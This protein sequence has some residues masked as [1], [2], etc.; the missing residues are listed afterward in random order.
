MDNS[1]WSNQHHHQHDG[2]VFKNEMFI[3]SGDE[4]QQTTPSS[5]SIT[6][7][8]E[9]A[10]DNGMNTNEPLI[11]GKPIMSWPFR[12]VGTAML[13]AVI[14]AAGVVFKNSPTLISA[15]QITTTTAATATETT[16][17]L[18]SS[19]EPKNQSDEWNCTQLDPEGTLWLR[20]NSS[21]HLTACGDGWNTKLV[22]LVCGELGYFGTNLNFTFI[23]DSKRAAGYDMFRL[24]EKDQ[25]AFELIDST[26]CNKGILQLHCQ[27]Y[28]CGRKSNQSKMDERYQYKNIL[29]NTIC[30]SLALAFSNNAAIKCTANIVS[31]RW[32]LTSYTC[33]EGKKEFVNNR[34]VGEMKWKLHAGSAEFSAPSEMP[35]AAHID[36][37]LQI[38]DVKRV[39]PYRQNYQFTYTGDVVLLELAT[40]LHLNDVIGSVCLTETSST[41]DP[42][43]RC[44]TTGW[45]S[46]LE[47]TDKMEQYMTNVS[48]VNVHTERC[49]NN[50]RGEPLNTDQIKCINDTGAPLMCYVAA[51][52]QWQLQGVLSIHGNCDKS[53]V[54]YNPITPD[55]ANWI[56][57]TV[58]NS[59][60]F[61]QMIVTS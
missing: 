37:S 36:E 29:Q 39:V 7:I 55:I 13:V 43:Q 2:S 11:N 61:E 56:R 35:A 17:E 38:V 52:G 25:L 50:I 32:A 18:I 23:S 24:T 15:P 26:Q 9:H 14:L 59:R 47:H 8:N 20:R 58:G 22:G 41:I 60:M 5:H 51:T 12:L 44:L 19:S 21:A 40:P 48:A 34:N 30:P 42:K 6:H 53:P 16:N 10:V 1:N 28:H 4:E 31:P 57:N 3:L 33:I 45:K 49:N 46:D 27:Q 54:I